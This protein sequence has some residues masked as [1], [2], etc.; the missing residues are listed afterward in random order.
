MQ[1]MG[2]DLTALGGVATLVFFTTVVA[3]YLWIEGKKRVILLLLFASLGGLLLSSALK[4]FISRP[5]PDVVRIFR[6]FIPAASPVATRCF[7]R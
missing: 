1:E 5:R 2:R 3:G 4:H 6:M 7:P